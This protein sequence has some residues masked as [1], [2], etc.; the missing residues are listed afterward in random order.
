MPDSDTIDSTEKF[1]QIWLRYINL[2]IDSIRFNLKNNI[3]LKPKEEF[4]KKNFHRNT[5]ALKTHFDIKLQQDLFWQTSYSN[6]NKNKNKQM[7]PN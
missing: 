4:F 2:L 1:P 7:G 3:G 5:P 6:E